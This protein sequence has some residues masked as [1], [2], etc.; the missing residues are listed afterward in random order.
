MLKQT[1]TIHCSQVGKSI[2]HQ[3]IQFHLKKHIPPLELEK[4]F[5]KRRADAVWEEK[6][7]I[8]EIQLSPLLL[9][10]ALS[11]IQDYSCLGYQVVWILHD[12]LFNGVKVLPVEKFLRKSCPTYFT[13]GET[14]YDQMEVINGKRRLYRGDPLPIDFAL[15]CIPFLEI[16]WRAW[17]LH[18]VG[19]LHTFCAVQGVEQVRQILKQHLPPSGFRWWLQ[20]I[21]FRLLEIVSTN[22]K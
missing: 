13:N 22:P 2:A 3:A 18:F 14:F 16:P 11:R 17:P 6:K 10:E 8:F 4:T 19:D 1:N 9:Q 20:F 15:P 21:G 7:I 5:Q 12:R